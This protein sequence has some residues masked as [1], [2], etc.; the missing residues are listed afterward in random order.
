MITPRFTQTNDGK[1]F[2]DTIYNLLALRGVQNLVREKQFG[3][4]KADIYFEIISFGNRRRF[5]VECKD[6]TETLTQK[7][8]SKIYSGYMGLFAPAT[9]TDLL[10]VSNGRLAPSAQ[11]YVD[12]VPNLSYQTFIDLRNSLIDLNSYLY[13]L[14]ERFMS[15]TTFNYYIDM[16]ATRPE[17]NAMPRPSRDARS[18]LLARIIEAKKPI[19]VFGAYGIGKTTLAK[20][21]FLDLLLSREADGRQPTPIYFSLDRMTMEQSLEGLL[22]TLFTSDFHADGYN[23]DLFRA[24]NASGNYVLLF[25]GIDEM[26]HRLSWEDFQY[27]FEQLELLTSQNPMSVLFG[28][29]TAFMNERE[30]QWAVHARPIDERELTLEIRSDYEEIELEP[31]DLARIKRFIREYCRWKYPKHPDLLARANHLLIER[32]NQRLQEIAKR[33]VQLMMILEL[34]PELRSPLDEIT[35]ATVYSLFVDEL[36]RREKRKKS[37][38]HSK[39]DYRRFAQRV[40]V[41]LWGRGGSR[42]IEASQIG[43]EVLTSFI[44]NP[45]EIDVV[46]RAFVSG[47]FLSAKG[48][49]HLHFPHRSIQEYLIAEFL[50]DHLEPSGILSQELATLNVQLE[51]L[52]SPEVIEFLVAQLSSSQKGNLF[53]VLRDC[54]IIPQELQNLLQSEKDCELLMDHAENTANTVSMILCLNNLLQRNDRERAARFARCLSVIVGNLAGRHDSR[55]ALGQQCLATVAV[56]F[57]CMIALIRRFKLEPDPLFVAIM[58]LEKYGTYKVR[59]AQSSRRIKVGNSREFTFDPVIYSLRKFMV[60]KIDGDVIK[61]S[62]IVTYIMNNLPLRGL[63]NNWSARPKFEEIAAGAAEIS[64]PKGTIGASFSSFLKRTTIRQ[65]S[66]IWETRGSKSEERP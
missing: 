13:G 1:K 15:D 51:T 32:N 39:A 46:R 34:M 2:E 20:K 60:E 57:I 8:I 5:A 10:I 49:K 21:L 17:D 31:L 37:R 22:G 61:S 59:Q 9:I 44:N 64:L 35:H 40:A 30:Y 65:S 41:W 14:K 66:G 55:S 29:P 23:F 33:P 38:R 62:E 6:Y 53:D 48:G 50:R 28:R 4:K 56:S 12:S 36:I 47:S 43:P 26:R 54:K 24:L 42:E 27:N 19:I 18:L 16:E 58:L 63:F 45:D 3:S 7:A 52:L 25:D 11:S